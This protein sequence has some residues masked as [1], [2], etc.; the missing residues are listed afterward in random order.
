MKKVY[1]I[2]GLDCVNCAMQLEEKINKT[3]LANVTINFLTEKIAIE[4]EVLND[5][6]VEKISKI[7]ENFE[8]GIKIIK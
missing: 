2:E 4:A 7:A 8:D 6:I 1:K 3:G 5:N